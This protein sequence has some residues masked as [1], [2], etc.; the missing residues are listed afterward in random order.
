MEALENTRTYREHISR[1]LIRDSHAGVEELSFNDLLDFVGDDIVSLQKTFDDCVD[2]DSFT[3]FG[4]GV[5]IE[6]SLALKALTKFFTHHIDIDVLPHSSAISFSEFLVT[7]VKV[8]SLNS[9][10]AESVPQTSLS[11]TIEEDGPLIVEPIPLDS[12]E[13]LR[14]RRLHHLHE[15]SMFSTGVC[16]SDESCYCPEPNPGRT[17]VKAVQKQSLKHDCATNF[18]SSSV[19]SSSFVPYSPCP[20]TRRVNRK[21]LFDTVEFYNCLRVLVKDSNNSKL[22]TEFMKLSPETFYSKDTDEDC[23][24]IFFSDI[25]HLFAIVGLGASRSWWEEE[26]EEFSLEQDVVGVVS[27]SDIM[28]FLNQVVESKKKDIDICHYLLAKLLWSDVLKGSIAKVSNAAITLDAKS[29][30]K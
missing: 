15:I 11:A 4:D 25:F 2:T 28:I 5:R 19:S 7:F 20:E 8:R 18:A 29:H 22:K 24:T 26:F 6:P 10:I 12:L 16:L 27:F 30:R 21:R 14:R 13:E 9:E 23:S 1:G 17:Q 3:A